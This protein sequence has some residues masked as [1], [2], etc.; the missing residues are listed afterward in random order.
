MQR[1]KDL[2]LDSKTTGALSGIRTFVRAQQLKNV[3][4]VK[5]ALSSLENYSLLKRSR[6]RFVRR[7]VKINFVNYQQCVDLMDT[8]ND[9]IY[10]PNHLHPFLNLILIRNLQPLPPP[11]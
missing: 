5:E 10:C 1:I 6:K 4:S 2:Y 8:G 3:K 7:R 11:Q 9:D